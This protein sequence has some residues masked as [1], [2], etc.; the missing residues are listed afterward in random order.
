[1]DRKI[2]GVAELLESYGPAVMAVSRREDLI[3]DLAVGGLSND[4][5]LPW[6]SAGKPIAAVAIAQLREKGLLDWDDAAAKFVPEF[7]QRGKDKITIRQ[8]L[9]HTGGFRWARLE[10]G[11]SWNEMLARI[12]DAPIEPNWVVGQKAGYHAVTSW[13]VLGEIVARLSGKRW[14]VYAK[15]EIF[16]PAGMVNCDFAEEAAFSPG[17]GARGPARE[18]GMFYE[19]MLRGGKTARGAQIISEKSVQELTSR[20]RVGMFDYTFK[21][22]IDWGLGF[23]L[24]SAQYG[25]EAP[26]GYGRYASPQTF[27]H[28]GRQCCTGFADPDPALAVAV[29]FAS[30]PGEAAHQQR[31][32]EILDRL[33]ENLGLA[34][35]RQ[36]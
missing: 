16:Q 24:N 27:G 36:A 12:C 9:T 2:E 1:M 35:Q 33:Y 14:Q 32:R 8:L 22:T 20:Q 11:L 13:F 4:I 7:A 30:Q 15:E 5:I 31:M 25:P 6:L 17:A 29:I 19:M 26:Y 23:I 34:N 10:K 28:G 21:H 18:L 3:A